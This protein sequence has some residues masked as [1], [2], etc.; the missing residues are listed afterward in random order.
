MVALAFA[1]HVRR[2]MANPSLVDQPQVTSFP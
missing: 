2:F 1:P